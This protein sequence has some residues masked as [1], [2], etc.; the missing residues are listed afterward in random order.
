MDQQSRV[1]EGVG[2]SI[3]AVFFVAFAQASEIVLA[4]EQDE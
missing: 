2:C 4:P 3:N 1:D